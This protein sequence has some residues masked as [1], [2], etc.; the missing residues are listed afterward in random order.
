MSEAM[1]KGKVIDELTAIVERAEHRA[2]AIVPKPAPV[3]NDPDLLV[4]PMLDEDEKYFL[5]AA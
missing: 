2:I 1:L 5:G 4:A 3:A